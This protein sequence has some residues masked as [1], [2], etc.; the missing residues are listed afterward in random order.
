MPLI[1]PSKQQYRLTR[2]IPWGLRNREG[3]PQNRPHHPPLCR[4]RH[5]TPRSLVSLCR[6]GNERASGA[7]E[8]HAAH[9]QRIQPRPGLR[10]R[11]VRSTST[12]LRC[13]PRRR[14]SILGLPT[15]H[16]PHGAK[17]PARPIRN[18][19][20][21]THARSFGS[22]HGS[23]TLHPPPKRRL[24]QLFLL[25]PHAPRLVQARVPMARYPASMGSAVDGLPEQ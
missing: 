23:K 13:H 24:H 22:T 2:P 16:G 19:K 21:T 8:R 5:T 6:C 4:R 9:L 20:T 10:P 25:L 7:D 15:F 12:H 3:C 17:L 1:P 11:H 14:Y 18:A